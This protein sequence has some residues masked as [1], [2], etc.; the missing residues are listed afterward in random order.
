M[1]GALVLLVAAV[2][3]SRSNQG[4]LYG[5]KIDATAPRVTLAELVSH[6]DAYEGKSVVLDGQ[7][8]GA[9]GDGDFYFKD[10]FDM[11]EADPPSPEVTSLKKGTPLRLYGIVKVR[12]L[13]SVQGEASREET[14]EA[15]EQQERSE[16]GS[17][18]EVYVKVVGRAVE[19]LK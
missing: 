18:G 8:G 14:K 12:R 15:S 1:V 9:C 13:Q 5:E 10:K 4:K 19:V 2:A 16:N 6:P 17:K 7:Y 3:C 11:I